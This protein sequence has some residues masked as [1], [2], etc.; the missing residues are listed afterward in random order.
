MN[1]SPLSQTHTPPNTVSRRSV[2]HGLAVV[3]HEVLGTGTGL[4]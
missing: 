3:G 2:A 1:T 4:R